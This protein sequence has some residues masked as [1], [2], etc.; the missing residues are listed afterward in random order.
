MFQKKSKGG[1]SRQNDIE[2][3]IRQDW[4]PPFLVILASLLFFVLYLCGVPG[5]YA[6]IPTVGLL[7]FVLAYST[8]LRHWARKR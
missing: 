5:K 6:T 4:W 7:I 3:R 8:A 1:Q 2:A